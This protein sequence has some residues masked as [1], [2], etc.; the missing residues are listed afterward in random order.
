MTE[1]QAR[2]VKALRDYNPD[3]LI[4]TGESEGG[5]TRP[6]FQVLLDGVTLRKEMGRRY[7]K[8]ET[9]RVV[10][11]PPGP[12][13]PQKKE[14]PIQLT[15]QWAGKGVHTEAEREKDRLSI[16]ARQEQILFLD[17]EEAALM[18][19]MLLGLRDQ[20]GDE[21]ADGTAGV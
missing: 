1:F 7:R 19:R 16:R 12:E 14:I 6:C 11:Y 3:A 21:D 10:W 13:S 8:E 15:L 4:L 5:I 9:L 20:A 18:M 2:A 17:E